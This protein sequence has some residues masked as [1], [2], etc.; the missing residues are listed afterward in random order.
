MVIIVN[1]QD[2]LDSFDLLRSS[3]QDLLISKA[4]TTLSAPV[5]SAS[6]SAQIWLDIIKWS[7]RKKQSTEHDN[8]Q[9]SGDEDDIDEEIEE[10]ESLYDKACA[11]VPR[12]DEEFEVSD[13][14]ECLLV[15][16]Q[17]C[18]AKLGKFTWHF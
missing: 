15:F 6:Y 9:I 17:L 14:E 5:A 7:G 18:S 4:L 11:W 12:D 16:I 13:E 2:P 3:S 8:S 1:W 10:H